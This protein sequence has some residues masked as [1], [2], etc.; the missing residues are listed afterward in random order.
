MAYII[1]KYLKEFDISGDMIQISKQKLVDER[2][3]F[4]NKDF[5]FFEGYKKYNLILS[6]MSLH[7]SS[8][9]NQIIKKLLNKCQKIQYYALHSRIRKVLVR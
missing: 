3:V 4:V 6:N 7:W 5:D 8:N 1:P 2:L 9:I